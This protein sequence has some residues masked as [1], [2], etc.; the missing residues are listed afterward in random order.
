MIIPTIIAS[1]VSL[2]LLFLV[3]RKE[4]K[5]EIV[6]NEQDDIKL[7][8]LPVIFGVVILSMA[9]IM[10]AISSYIITIIFTIF[11]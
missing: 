8:R 2:T 6:V 5:G 1:L 4:L 11:I 10:L 3:F 7:E 9:T